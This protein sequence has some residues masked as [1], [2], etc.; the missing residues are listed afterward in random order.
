MAADALHYVRHRKW[1][2]GISVR[3]YFSTKGQGGLNSRCLVCFV[4]R[5]CTSAA[6]LSCNAR[7]GPR[8][9]SRL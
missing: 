4:S 3:Q 2:A 7:P 1:V 5:F 8:C 6:A 9:S